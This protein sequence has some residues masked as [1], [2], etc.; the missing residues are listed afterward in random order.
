M[1]RTIRNC[2]LPIFRRVCPE[3]W[4]KL[5]PTGD[6]TVRHCDQC[7]QEVYLCTTDEQ[8]LSHARA[9]HCIAREIP[10]ESEV[11]GIYLGRPKYVPPT[12][13]RQEE[14]LRLSRRED[15]IKDA[16]KNVR[17][18]RSCPRCHY[19]APSWRTVCRVCGEHI[20][21]MH[22]RGD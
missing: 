13:P 12:T 9:G 3:R 4:E 11:P 18:P 20:G 5:T 7:N 10:D 2:P 17:S 14:A 8:T 21:R 1:N 6:A 15:G 22:E 19:P 16:L